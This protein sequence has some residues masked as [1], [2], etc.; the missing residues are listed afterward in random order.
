MLMHNSVATDTATTFGKYSIWGNND[1]RF[2]ETLCNRI[3]FVSSS[4][5]KILEEPQTSLC[6]TFGYDFVRAI[7]LGP[8]PGEWVP[9]LGPTVLWYVISPVSL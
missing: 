6:R 9:G 5:V 4:V 1:S 3:V 2:L 7:G 8:L